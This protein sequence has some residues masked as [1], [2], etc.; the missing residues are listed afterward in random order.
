MCTRSGDRW[1]L[2]T[3]YQNS[4]ELIFIGMFVCLCVY[5]NLPKPFT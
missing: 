1:K 4:K 5:M 2:Q 3:N